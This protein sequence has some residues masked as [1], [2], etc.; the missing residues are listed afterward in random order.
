MSSETRVTT[1]GRPPTTRRR[2]NLSVLHPLLDTTPTPPP[3]VAAAS[4]LP[5]RKCHASA[6]AQ[7]AVEKAQ[8][9]RGE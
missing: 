1:R 4:G 6:R 5:S 8:E 2:T 9:D 7:A 3:A